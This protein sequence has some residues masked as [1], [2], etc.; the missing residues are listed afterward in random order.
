MSNV[1][2]FLESVGQDAAL[3]HA[4]GEHLQDVAECL[5]LEPQA[6]AAVLSTDK[7]LIS[8]LTHAMPVICC[9]IMPGKDDDDDDSPDRDDD[10]VR[11]LAEAPCIA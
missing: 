8:T 4:I 6:R 2:R 10:E 5:Q 11:L 9:G 7:V 1:I 3:R